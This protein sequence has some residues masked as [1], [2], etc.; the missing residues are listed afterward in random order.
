M[1]KKSSGQ[2]AIHIEWAKHL[3]KEGR[4]FFWKEERQKLR[5]WLQKIKKE[6]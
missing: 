4:R 2:F 1:S 5:K 6:N 3:R